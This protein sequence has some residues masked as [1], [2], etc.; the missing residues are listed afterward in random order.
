MST[1]SADY[2]SAHRRTC[3]K[4]SRS[5]SSPPPSASS[6]PHPSWAAWP[7]DVV[8]LTS[9]AVLGDQ[10]GGPRRQGERP[11]GPLPLLLVPTASGLLRDRV[12]DHV[13]SQYVARDLHDAQGVLRI[14]QAGAG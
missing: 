1:P 14:L 11:P 13:V 9:G 7:A 3:G 12:A 5:S 8:A 4:T 10:V 2:C 6:P